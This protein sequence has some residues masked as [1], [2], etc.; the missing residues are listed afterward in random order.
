MTE[1]AP[2]AVRRGPGAFS[3]RQTLDR[4]GL[5]VLM[6]IGAVLGVAFAMGRL[7][8]VDTPI[9]WDA[10]H[11]AH[12]Y[13]AFWTCEPTCSYLYPPPLAQVAG[14]FSW[15][16][17]VVAWTLVLFAGWWA[18][19]RQWSFPTFAL[20]V[21][22]VAAIGYGNPLSN[23]LD[24]T[25]IG[26]P[27]ILIAA[28]C[29]IGFRYP[30]AWAFVVLTKIAPGIGLLWFA[31]R[32]EWRNLGI[33]LG[34]TAGI[35]VVSFVLAPGAWADYVDFI[36]ANATA[37]S[38][39]PLV[40]IPFLI[41]F[42]MSVALIT[43]GALTNRRWTVPISVGWAALALYEWTFMTIWMAALPLLDRRLRPATIPI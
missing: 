7:R 14:L 1:G 4:F 8:A 33:A 37:T 3:F 20:S 16:V 18:A 12:Y 13:S 26:N 39:E 17:F 43:W 5:I 9:F 27:Q 41:R 40:P 32:R 6:A 30:A 28:V 38:P 29:V 25:A 24:Q 35:A 36:K 11:A 42:P 2:P 34:V 19:T 22:V 15:P 23:A 31:V 10:G 21:I